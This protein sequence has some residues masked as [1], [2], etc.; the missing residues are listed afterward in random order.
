MRREV[1]INDVYLAG[2]TGQGPAIVGGL[3]LL[4][5][6][7]GLTVLGPQPASVRTMHWGR[8]ST[9]SC[10]QLA[11]LPDG[12]PA[13]APWHLMTYEFRLKPGQG[14]APKPMAATEDA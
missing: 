1:R 8:A 4:A 9:I 12:R 7:R 5:D 2:S 10:R 13:E 14:V 11:Q 6:D 3:A